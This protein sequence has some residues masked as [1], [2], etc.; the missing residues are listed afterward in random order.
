MIENNYH[1]LSLVLES[2]DIFS[3]NSLKPRAPWLALKCKQEA[4]LM[5]DFS[6]KWDTST[7]ID[8]KHHCWGLFFLIFVS[9]AMA[10]AEGSYATRG[11][12]VSG[13][14]NL[15]CKE[16]YKRHSER[17]CLSPLP[18]VPTQK[19]ARKTQGTCC[20]HSDLH[21]PY[22]APFSGFCI[23][24]LHTQKMYFE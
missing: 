7:P 14:I 1:F 22:R 24:P 10:V 8:P 5:C 16:Q 6:Q 21:P 17:A 4:F 2:R 9:L 18:S 19:R 12:A 15:S 20:N 13:I 3:F 23:F 11:L